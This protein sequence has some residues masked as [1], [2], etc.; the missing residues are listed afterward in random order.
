M[1][2]RNRIT[3]CFVIVL[4][5]GCSKQQ[6]TEDLPKPTIISGKVRNMEV[7]PTSRELSV[8]VIDFRERK[9]VFKDSIKD[10]GTFHIVFDLYTPQDIIMNPLVNKIILY[11]GDSIFIELDFKDIG[12][13]N[14]SGDR[15]ETNRAMQNY[16]KSNASIVNFYSSKRLDI[17]AYKLFSDSI[18]TDA[19]LKQK[20][21]I[22]QEN[23]PADFIQWSTDLV[24]INYYHSILY[25]P[26]RYYGMDE[27]GFKSWFD[28]TNYYDFLNDIE[29]G[30]SDFRN[31][32]VHTDIYN[33]TGVYGPTISRRLG[34]KM[35]EGKVLSAEDVIE[36]VIDT[37]NNGVFKELLLGTIFYQFLL[38]YDIDNYN[39][40]REV[41]DVNIKEPFIKLPLY[42]FHNNLIEN[43][44]NPKIASDAIFSKMGVAGKEL[45][46]S[47]IEENKGKV[48]FID[49]W[50]TWCKP[51]IEGMKTAKEIMPQYENDDIEFIF[52]CIRSTEENWQ[53]ALS[54][55]EIGGK[56]YFC[57]NEQSRDISI[58]LGVE[59]IPYYF[60]INKEGYIVQE[61][62][63]GISSSQDLIVELL[64][65]AE[66]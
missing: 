1:N 57:T 66:N 38:T 56:H 23:P 17:D 42:N 43:L 37:Q 55:I 61:K 30:F 40:F 13:V 9:S 3:F 65:D 28:S 6:A 26:L 35:P 11:P 58:A 29:T 44:D 54:K 53:A 41:I 19:F 14:F 62:S 2:E 16:I 32:I 49:L 63:Y 8:E 64:Q 5:L 31:R 4:F 39:D 47:I 7:Y 21:F 60:I 22:E 12:N 48:L 10:D 59:A 20:T 46:N 27:K 34:N 25:Y 52:L 15:I 50:A 45:L 33:L 36:E 51:C 24:N 18:R